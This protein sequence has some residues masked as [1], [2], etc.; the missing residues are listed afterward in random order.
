[1][2]VMTLAYGAAQIIA[3]VFTGYLTAAFGSY[4]LGLYLSAGVMIIGAVFLLGLVR[5]ERRTV[6]EEAFG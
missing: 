2:G 4:N 5:L 6:G 1:M 3:P